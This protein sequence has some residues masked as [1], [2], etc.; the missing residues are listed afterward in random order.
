MDAYKVLNIVA[1]TIAIMYF[2]TAMGTMACD[3]GMLVAD[4][5]EKKQD[6]SNSQ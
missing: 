5:Y 6:K 4:M 2:L 1:I 3:R